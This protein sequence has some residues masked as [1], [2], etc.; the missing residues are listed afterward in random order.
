M[1]SLPPSH[2]AATAPATDRELADPRDRAVA[3][4]MDR[5]ARSP[6]PGPRAVD[7][8]RELE[9]RPAR[10]AVHDRAV[11]PEARAVARAVEG[12]ARGAGKLDRAALVG[13]D[14][15]DR[16]ANF[17]LGRKPCAMDQR[18]EAVRV[19][20]FAGGREKGA[21]LAAAAQHMCGAECGVE[22]I[23]VAHAV[24]QR[25]YLGRLAHGRPNGGDGAVEIVGFA[26][27]D[28]E[29]VAGPER[30]RLNRRDR[31][32]RVAPRAQDR[33]A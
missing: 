27:Q 18:V 30:V 1:R 11:G 2:P 16:G 9:Q 5:L 22:R 12:R 21:D 7:P 23:E 3:V 4:F 13:A 20:D 19:A 6:C 17:G 24:Q 15:R 28:H 32:A 31:K 10:G 29:I 25:Q 33:E 8:R 14:A 26:A